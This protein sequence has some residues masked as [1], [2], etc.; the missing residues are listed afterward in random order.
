MHSMCFVQFPPSL[1]Q[2]S[3]KFRHHSNNLTIHV[4]CESSYFSGV[5]RYK[6]FAIA[7]MEPKYEPYTDWFS[8]TIRSIHMNP[9]SLQLSLCVEV[10]YY[11]TH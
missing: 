8:A 4:A 3:V 9:D 6:H 5:Q 2:T 10:W 7:I 11:L 1:W